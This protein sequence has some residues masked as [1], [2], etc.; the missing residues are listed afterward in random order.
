M[1]IAD[2][3]GLSS[4]INEAILRLAGERRISGVSV[5]VDLVSGEMAKALSATPVKISLHLDI[6]EDKK[7]PFW[8]RSLQGMRENGSST[9]QDFT[10]Q[11]IRFRELFGRDPEMIDGHAYAHILPGI[12]KSYVEFLKEHFPGS[13]PLTRL[14]LMP[15]PGEMIV[16]SKSRLKALFWHRIAQSFR[17]RY[18]HLPAN[19]FLVGIY[20]FD[21]EDS[22][23]TE[24]M[25]I[26]L[27]KTN[28]ETW[29]VCH[30]SLDSQNG[31]F[32]MIENDFLL[33]R[34][35]P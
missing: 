3:F 8:W 25:R 20:S 7:G 18:P 4:G 10:R 29:M 14:P 1:I 24:Q 2:D 16:G 6:L 22:L 26:F 13:P 35:F 15:F 17:R 32:R 21:A 33:G 30:P 5:L 34:S 12:R 19:Q 23:I 27:A 9:R 11:L 28:D 31:R